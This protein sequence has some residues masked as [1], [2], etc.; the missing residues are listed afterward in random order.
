MRKAF[1]MVTKAYKWYPRMNPSHNCL[2]CRSGWF[3]T[4]MVLSTALF[5]KPAFKNLIVNGIVLAEDGHKMSKSKKNYPDPML[6]VNS[7]GADALRMYLINSPVCV[8]VC[9]CVCI[10]ICV[11][12]HACVYVCTVCEYHCYVLEYLK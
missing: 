1:L 9:M 2:C 8:C 4:L 12:V 7:F 5:D 6:V 10:Y 3:Y 11:C